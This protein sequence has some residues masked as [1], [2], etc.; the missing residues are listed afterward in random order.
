MHDVV[1]IRAIV[2]LPGEEKVLIRLVYDQPC[3]SVMCDL[4]QPVQ[5]LPRQS[6]TCNEGPPSLSLCLCSCD[7]SPQRD[8]TGFQIDVSISPY[9]VLPFCCREGLP[10][11]L[12]GLT[13]YTSFGGV[14]LADSSS[15]QSRSGNQVSGLL[16]PYAMV[17][18]HLREACITQTMS[19]V[20]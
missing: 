15:S 16:G 11:G 2:L 12:Q 13:M 7:L 20:Q 18:P 4:C 1:C 5:L 8:K 10:V 3:P 9:L 17:C 6:H 14:A 19:L